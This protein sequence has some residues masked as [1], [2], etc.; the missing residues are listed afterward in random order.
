MDQPHTSDTDDQGTAPQN[1]QG[2]Q[3]ADGERGE[4]V[5]RLRERFLLGG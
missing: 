2:K 1:D 5:A 4:V 3:L